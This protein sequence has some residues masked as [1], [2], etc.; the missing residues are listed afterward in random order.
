MAL[1]V[2]VCTAYWRSGEY[3][4][5]RYRENGADRLDISS[6]NKS[7]RRVLLLRIDLDLDLP[8]TEIIR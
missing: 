1:T 4:R 7:F 2:E 5:T 8:P 3:E 6:G